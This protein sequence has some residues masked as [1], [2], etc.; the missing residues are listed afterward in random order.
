M[1]GSQASKK[2]GQTYLKT[3]KLKDRCHHCKNIRADILT[4]QIVKILKRISISQDTLDILHDELKDKI[5]ARSDVRQKQIEQLEGKLTE[6]S[7]QKK[8]NL[9][10]LMSKDHETSITLNIYTNMEHMLDDD[11]QQINVKLATLKKT[12]KEFRN[13]SLSIF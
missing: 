8:E 4:P 2:K 11:K 1:S 7:E 12:D 6:I 5:K 9:R 10:R 13:S 3:S